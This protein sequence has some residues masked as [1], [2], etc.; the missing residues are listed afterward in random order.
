ML[1]EIAIS[2]GYQADAGLIGLLQSFLHINRPDATASSIRGY[3]WVS[4]S[5][6]HGD[7]F[8]DIRCN[9]TILALQQSDR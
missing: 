1:P 8:V 9:N 2:F 6:F 4:G 5:W 7:F 3:D